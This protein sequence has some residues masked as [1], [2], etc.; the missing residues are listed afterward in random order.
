MLKIKKI[1]EVIAIFPVTLPCMSST[2]FLVSVQAL[3][4]LHGTPSWHR[5]V[6][7][8]LFTW[9]ESQEWPKI[10]SRGVNL[11]IWMV[12]VAFAGLKSS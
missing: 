2:S 1:R 12:M 11:F 3:V 8:Q 10:R 9:Q 7:I 5:P 4:L 6:E